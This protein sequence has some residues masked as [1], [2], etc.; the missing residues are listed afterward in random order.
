MKFARDAKYGFVDQMEQGV[1]EDGMW[2][3]RSMGYHSY[4]VSAITYHLCPF[5]KRARPLG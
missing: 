2:Y 3:E 5:G 1:L 4:T